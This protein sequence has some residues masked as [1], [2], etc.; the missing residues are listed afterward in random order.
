MKIAIFST[1]RYDREYLEKF[2]HDGKHQLQFFDESLQVANATLASG[3]DAICVFVNDIVDAPTISELSQL[4]IRIIALRC[5]G[6]NNVD[7][8][9]AK[10]KNIKI[11]RVPAYSPQAVAEHAVA[12][13]L[14]L[15]RNTHKA[16]NRVKNNNFSL[17]KLT[18]FNLYQK[19]VGV[20]GTG[21]IGQAFCEIMNGFG[22]NIIAFDIVQSQELISKGI[23]YKSLDEIFQL[24][25]II[26]IHCPL[27]A[28]TQYLINSSA[29]AKMKD[30]V[31]LI[32]TSRGAVIDTQAAIDGLKTKKLGYLGIDVYEK[33]SPLFFKDLSETIIEDD[34]FTQ[35]LTFPNVLVTGHQGFLTKEALDEIAKTTLNNLSDFENGLELK[36]EV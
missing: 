21:K 9:A 3:C 32:N 31:M 16:Y 34:V 28:A 5:A 36:N 23:M 27:N 1:K 13:I 8:K 29:L 26:S 14:T 18:G 4:G 15:N 2:N 25:D 22:C 17:E 11:V 35:L 6:F 12:L 33:E 20:I 30:G 19:T 10:E 7:L 24:S